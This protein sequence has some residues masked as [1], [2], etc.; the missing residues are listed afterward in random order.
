[1]GSVSG[2]PFDVKLHYTD[3][4]R[5]PPEVEKENNAPPEILLNP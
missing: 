2:E 1:L 3:R 5:L 4:Y